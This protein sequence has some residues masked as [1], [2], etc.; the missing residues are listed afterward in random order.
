[1]RQVMLQY[2]EPS[3]ESYQVYFKRIF[4]IDLKKLCF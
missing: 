4:D 2:L 3:I 1:M